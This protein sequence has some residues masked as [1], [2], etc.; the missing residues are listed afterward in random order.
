MTA[1]NSLLPRRITQKTAPLVLTT[2]WAAAVANVVD[3]GKVVNVKRLLVS[4]A[5]SG[6]AVVSVKLVRAGYGGNAE[7]PIVPAGSVTAGAGVSVLPDGWLLTLEEGDS[8]MVKAASGSSV[9]A[10]CGYSVVE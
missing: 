1:P 6:A 8:L 3:S 9:A 10:I 2:T 5:G 7:Y 4:N